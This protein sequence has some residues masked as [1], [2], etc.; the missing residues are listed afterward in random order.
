[1]TKEQWLNECDTCGTKGEDEIWAKIIHETGEGGNAVF[2]L[3]GDC[4]DVFFDQFKE[5]AQ[6]REGITS[7]L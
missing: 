7:E 5:V 6:K 3:C 4:S 2:Y 1:M